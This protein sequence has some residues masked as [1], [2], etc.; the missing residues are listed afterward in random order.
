MNITSVLFGAIAIIICVLP[1]VMLNRNKKKRDAQLL[2]SL[3]NIAAQN[4]CRIDKRDIFGSFAI[5]M[6]ETNNFVFFHRHTKEKE[7]E[8]FVDLDEVQSCKVINTSRT[9]R[10]KGGNQKVIDKLE[11]SFRPKTPNKPEIKFEFFNSDVSVQLSGELQSIVKWSNLI[12][13]RLKFKK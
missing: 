13:D 7:V 11:L 3:S 10:N 8:K 12:N 2:L 6:D 1:F 5:G 9:I 4:N